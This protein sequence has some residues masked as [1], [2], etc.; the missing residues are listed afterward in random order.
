VAR[1]RQEHGIAVGRGVRDD[2]GADRPAGADARLDDDLLTERVRKLRSQH[3]RNGIGRAARGPER[4]DEPN[5][6]GRILLRARAAG[7]KRACQQNGGDRI[8]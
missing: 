8:R 2:L 7:G 5:G 4:E 3:A 6:L 1:T